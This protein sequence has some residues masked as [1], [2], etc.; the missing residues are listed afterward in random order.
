MAR[1]IRA[2]CVEI[3]NAAVVVVLIFLK[4][5]GLCGRL[6]YSSY[7]YTE[8]SMTCTNFCASA[9]PFA[10]FHV[11]AICEGLYNKLQITGDYRKHE[12]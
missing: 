1:R 9:T 7:F 4:H 5:N 2:H 11:H 8:E 10:S 6:A 12:G 3:K